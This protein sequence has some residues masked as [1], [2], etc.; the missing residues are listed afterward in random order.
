MLEREEERAPLLD[1]ATPCHYTEE[2]VRP[3]PPHSK[4]WLLG[5]FLAIFSGILF[6]A[7][8]FLVKYYR[9]EAVE[10]LLVRSG[11]QTVLMAAVV[12]KNEREKNQKKVDISVLTRR[13]FVPSRRL[14]RLLVILQGLFT[15]LRILFTFASVLYMP[16]GDSL[17]IVFTEPLWTILLSRVILRISISGWK[18]MFGCLLVCGMVLCVQPP[19]LFPSDS[20]VPAGQTSRNDTERKEIDEDEPNGEPH[21]YLGVLLALGTAV[22]GA[23]TNVCIARCEGVSSKVLVFYSGLGGAVIALICSAFDPENKIIFNI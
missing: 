11:L 14:D 6:T 19:F 21:Y 12:G 8:N 17:T 3:Q 7:N 13:S 20:Q 10:M 18:M 23:L 16:L 9:V 22:M 5:S 1:G 2:N 15:G 4:P